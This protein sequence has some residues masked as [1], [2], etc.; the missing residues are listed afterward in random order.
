MAEVSVTAPMISTID[1]DNSVLVATELL[2]SSFGF[3][4]SIFAPAED[5]LHQARLTIPNA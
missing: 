4:T 1:D 3:E 2:I 5:F